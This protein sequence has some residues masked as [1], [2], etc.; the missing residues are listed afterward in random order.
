MSK[1]MDDRRHAYN[2]GLVGSDSITNWHK[3]IQLDD[4]DGSLSSGYGSYYCDNGINIAILALTLAGL[5]T[6]FYVLYTKITMLV[7]RRRRHAIEYNT[8]VHQPPDNSINSMEEISY[9]LSMGSSNIS[10]IRKTLS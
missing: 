10:H 2:P 5:A 7:G 4:N 9:F 8:P 6:M 3:R 1:I